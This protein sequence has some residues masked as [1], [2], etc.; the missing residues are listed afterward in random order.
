MT[1]TW[2]NIEGAKDELV[3]K[4]KEVWGKTTD[5]PETQAKGIAQQVEGEVKQ[6]AASGRG[7]QE[8]LQESA[9]ERALAAQEQVKRQISETHESVSA[10]ADE[11]LKEAIAEGKRLKEEAARQAEELR[12]RA[13]EENERKKEEVREEAVE[14]NKRAQEIEVKANEAIAGTLHHIEEKEREANNPL[15]E[16]SNHPEE[17]VKIESK[18]SVPNTIPLDVDEPVGVDFKVNNERTSG[19]FIGEDNHL[20]ENAT[21]RTDVTPSLTKE[22]VEMKPN[23][24]SEVTL[25]QDEDKNLTP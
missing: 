10:S 2:K 9:H 8:E 11:N 3:G 18:N 6:A 15:I 7:N 4:I 21:E 14:A 23:E 22:I 24:H 1:D 20:D 12:Q 13:I 5:N 25:T 16:T 17:I 19:E